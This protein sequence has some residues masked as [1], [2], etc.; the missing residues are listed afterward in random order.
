MSRPYILGLTGSIGMGKSATA[1][2]FRARGVGGGEEG[3]F[4][5]SHQRVHDCLQ[6]RDRRGVIENAR[7]KLV[8]VDAGFAARI[9]KRRLDRLDERSASA[10]Q[11]THDRVGIEHRHAESAQHCRRGRLAHADRAGEA[12]DHHRCYALLG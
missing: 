10:L 5:L 6:T 2:M 12:E 1:A 7:R 9:G 11:A 4:G 3:R 8:A